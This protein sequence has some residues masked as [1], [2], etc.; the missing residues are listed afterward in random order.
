MAEFV[1]ISYETSKGIVIGRFIAAEKVQARL[2]I[3]SV[4]VL[5]PATLRKF[6]LD[7]K[8][9]YLLQLLLNITPHTGCTLSI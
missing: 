1:A 3:T 8:L 7:K 6:S 5:N 9:T 2:V 4:A